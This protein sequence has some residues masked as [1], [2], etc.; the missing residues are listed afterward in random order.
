MPTAPAPLSTVDRGVTIV[1]LGPDCENLSEVKLDTLRDTLLK[2]GDQADP[3]LVVVDLSHTKFFG[4]SFI[5]ILFGM[6]NKLNARG[7][8][9]LALC[10]LTSYCAEVLAVTH[11]DTLWPAY[12]D[13]RAAVEHLAAAPRS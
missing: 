1:T 6:W 8:A 9:R 13:R 2:L 5:E 10:G 7:G 12:A 11:L 3:P 4:S